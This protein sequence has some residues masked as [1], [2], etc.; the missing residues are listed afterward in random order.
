MIDDQWR[1]AAHF[2]ETAAE[3]QPDEERILHHL[4]ACYLHLE[5]KDR[6]LQ[7]LEKISESRPDEFNIQYL[8]ANLCE[9]EGKVDKAILG[10]KRAIKSIVGKDNIAP[11]ADVYYRLG[12]LYVKKGDFQKALE[13]HLKLM[14]TGV[15]TEPAKLQCE[16]GQ[17]YFQI[18]DIK[19]AME[20]FKKA[21]ELDP[22]LA[23]VH[24]YLAICNEKLGNVKEAISETELYL[25]E[26]PDNWVMLLGLADL[27]EKTRH[28]AKAESLEQ[29]AVTILKKNVSEGSKNSSEYLAFSHLLRKQNHTEEALEVLKQATTIPLDKESNRDVHYNLAGLYYDTNRYDKVE[30][31]IK[32]TL[33]ID[34][35]CHQAYNFLGYFYVERG[36]KLD[37]AIQ[38]I[39]KAL[40]ADPENGAYLDSLGWAYYKEATIEGKV[41][42]LQLALEK[43]IAASKR[44]EDPL[45]LEHLGEV[46]YC[47]GHWEKAEGLWKKAIKLQKEGTKDTPSIHNI[48]KRIE[49]IQHLKA[50]ESSKEKVVSN[51]V[52]P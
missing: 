49:K 20:T 2:F 13:F 4:A 11:L 28:E 40:E 30:E 39:K 43:L 3:L 18:N 33:E 23:I 6:A 8:Y 10:Y 51:Y 16:I 46:Y 47:L 26:Y 35:N 9:M 38:L 14:D 19:K 7:T 31:E 50:L 27:Y 52:H 25:T 29:R 22:S 37:E 41:N 42:K 45:I 17:I 12:H 21:E 48:E 44:V 15:V 32:N 1:T 34:P 24:F 5:D 36:V